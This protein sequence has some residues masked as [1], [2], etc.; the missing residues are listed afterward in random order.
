MTQ[1]H[2]IGIGGIGMSAL[3]RILL[4]KGISVSGSDK[5][6][7]LLLDQLEDEGAS[8]LRSHDA[9]FIQ[10][11]MCIVYSSSISQEN[12]EWQRAKEL[13][14]P[15]LHRS[16][17]L[18]LLMRGQKS[19]LVTGT[20]GKTTTTSLLAT[21]LVEAKCDPSFAVGGVLDSLQTNGRFGKGPF[22]V[23]EADESDGSFLRTSAF[24][25][26]VTNFDLDH[27]DFWKTEE[28]LRSAFAQFFSQVQEESHLFWCCDDRRLK[29]MHPRG[30]SYGFSPEAELRIL[31]CKEEA[32]GVSFTLQ[33][34]GRE[35]R[36]IFLPLLGHHNALNATAVFGLGLA[37]AIPET[38]IR[39]ALSNFSGV[40]K[41][42]E[43]RGGAGG[44]T[45]FE[46]YAHHPAEI[47]ATL[48]ALRSF[49]KERRI[50]ALLQPHRP[51]RVRDLWD[52]FKDACDTA[53][54]VI[55]TDIYNAG[56]PSLEGI[57]SQNLAQCMKEN[58]GDKLHFSSREQL[59]KNVF[60]LLQPL[61]LLITLGAGDIGEVIDPLTTRLGKEGKKWK[62][63]LICG[64]TSPEREVSLSSAKTL[65][66]WADPALYEWVGFPID[67]KGHWGMWQGNDF[68]QTF[69][70]PPPGEREEVLSLEIFK[71]LLN[72]DIALP[73]LHG[74]EGE[75]GMI[76][77]LLT[78]LQMPYAGCDYRSSSLCMHKRWTKEVA[79]AHGVKVAPYL[80]FRQEEEFSAI[81]QAVKAKLSFPVWVKPVH[82]GSSIGVAR[83]EKIED[84][85]KK[86][87]TAFTFDSEILI[88]EHIEGR[89]IEFGIV[90]NSPL[91]VGPPCE[92][93]SRGEFVGYEDKYGE[94]A[95]P[96]QIPATVPEEKQ[97]EGKNLAKRVYQL[98]GCEGLA[99]IDF[100]F[101]NKGEYWLNEANP[102]PGCTP[103]SAFPLLS[104]EFPPTALFDRL[105]AS[106]L[107]RHRKRKA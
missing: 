73:V 65:V 58:L 76:Q 78:T 87:R 54:L 11:G 46:D 20:H 107:H 30:I 89:E 80:S 59:E 25:A 94:K 27:M 19:L 21:L 95:F 61:D 79:L 13:S 15:L 32:L 66:S 6:E 44:V 10:E 18:D 103:T 42:L 101:D 68:S 71:A 98:L 39:R 88:E 28:N 90:G 49:A 81:E 84:L 104:A 31:S 16:E 75:D 26:I 67:R 100:F 82:L 34:K 41:R 8:V 45:F 35:Y 12:Q 5:K 93:L 24:G 29:E 14:L 52:D 51:S 91:W 105:I 48:S 69:V 37:L 63:A 57:S 106:A 86:V 22:F 38:T 47:K 4:Q 74:P 60:P 23:A 72:C 55:L 40:K 85:E 102:F 36:D 50:V 92:I 83:V 97:E 17:L 43:K 3:A 1:Y 96:Y 53:D 99:R 33:F 70:S 77:G 7:T 64:G 56:E 2:L 9:T 62:I